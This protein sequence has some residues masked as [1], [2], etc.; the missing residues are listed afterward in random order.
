MI[1][2]LKVQSQNEV[3]DNISNYI[4]NYLQKQR[5]VLWLLSGGSNLILEAK[6]MQT[7]PDDLTKNLTISLV[8][9]R[10]GLYNHPDSNFKQLLDL[11]FFQ[12]QAMLV[13]ILDQTNPNIESTCQNFINQIQP[14]LETHHVIAQLGIGQDGHIAGILPDSPAVDSDQLVI[15]YQSDQF[16]RI[17]F[18]L[19]A[20][21][22]FQQIY[23]V[24]LDQT[25]QN[26]IT[27]LNNQ[28]HRTKINYQQ[29]PAL[30]LNRLNHVYVYNK[31]IEEA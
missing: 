8:D 22:K 27:E 20:F 3:I 6:I 10:F 29:F 5:S 7:I 4:T 12:K 24:A 13:P 23:L 26:I 15:H 28:N 21:L 1:H 25:K 19:K 16:N 17:S 30:Y 9:E 18:T 31:W 2:Y 11:N 14:L